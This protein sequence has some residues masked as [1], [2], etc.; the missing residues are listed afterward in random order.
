MSDPDPCQSAQNELSKTVEEPKKKGNKKQRRTER[1]INKVKAGEEPTEKE[2]EFLKKYF[3][4]AVEVLTKWAEEYV[5]EEKR[6]NDKL[7]AAL[8]DRQKSHREKA[9]EILER[10]EDVLAHYPNPLTD[11]EDLI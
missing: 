11:E 3:G 10:E 9:E 2:K 6:I 7:D 8:A 5:K 4:E 1:I